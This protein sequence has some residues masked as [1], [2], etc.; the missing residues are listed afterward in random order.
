MGR[1]IHSRL[2]KKKCSQIQGRKWA[3]QIEHIELFRK[4]MLEII[5]ENIERVEFVQLILFLRFQ[6]HDGNRFKQNLET[7]LERIKFVV[8]V[9]LILL[10]LKFQLHVVNELKPNFEFPHM[11]SRKSARL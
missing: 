11:Y 8:Y 4:Y 5:L 9:Q 7:I 10:M 2:G 6:L 3:A 1:L